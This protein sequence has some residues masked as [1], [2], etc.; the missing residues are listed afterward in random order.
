[1]DVKPKLYNHLSARDAEAHEAPFADGRTRSMISRPTAIWRLLSYLGITLVCLPIQILLRRVAG[2]RV[3]EPFCTW[4]HRRAVAAFGV[5]VIEIGKQTA[6][7]PTL[8]VANHASY[9]DIELL[10]SRIDGTFIAMEQVSQWPLF[11]LLS[12]L[13]DSVF[14]DRQ[15]KSIAAQQ[16]QITERFDRGQN[17]IMFPEGASYTATHLLPFRSSLFAVAK[18]EVSGSPIAVQPVSIGFARL[19]GLPLGRNLRSYY[20]W[21]GDA[22]IDQHIVAAAGLGRLTVVMEWHTPKTLDDF[23][24]SRKALS[25]YCESCIKA[26]M[27]RARS[28]AVSA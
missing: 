27:A 5:R 15:A 1:M 22:P 21:Y 24:G 8:F 28:T 23:Q 17:L 12:R 2:P 11:G 16:R 13:Q 4:Y 20:G 3:W 18:H 25:A 19:D 6:T 9:L 10:G 14:I 26:G 7:R